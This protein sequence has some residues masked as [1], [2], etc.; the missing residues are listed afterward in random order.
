LP[1]DW[2]AM[3]WGTK[4]GDWEAGNID[5]D[6]DGASNFR[7]F[8]AGTDPTDRRSVLRTR[9]VQTRQG[10]FLEW[11]TQPGFVYQVVHS[12]NLISWSN[13]GGPRFAH[14]TTDSVPIAGGAA[15]GFYRVTRLR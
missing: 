7:E 14:G 1:D 12:G 8:Q 15:S 10:N 13:V 9:L 3:H 4:E 6:G 2:Q 5:S 11:N